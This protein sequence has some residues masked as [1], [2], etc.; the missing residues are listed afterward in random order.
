MFFHT[1]QSREKSPSGTGSR[2][3]DGS[4]AIK[5]RLDFALTLHGNWVWFVMI[6]KMLKGTAS[7]WR[8]CLQGVDTTSKGDTMVSPGREGDEEQAAIRK[9]RNDNAVNIFCL[10]HILKVKD[11]TGEGHGQDAVSLTV[12]QTITHKDIHNANVRESLT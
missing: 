8:R 9:H 5:F 7:G 11:G 12:L 6:Y 10:K 1:R 4:M 2:R 3:A